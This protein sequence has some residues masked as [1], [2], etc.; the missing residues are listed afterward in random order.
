MGSLVGTYIF[1]SVG[2][3]QNDDRSDLDLLAVVQNGSGKVEESSVLACVPTRFANMKPSISWYGQDRIREMYQNGEL[4]AWH[5]HAE[6][7]PVFELHPFLASLGRPQPYEDSALDVGSFQK[8]LRGIPEQIASN[9]YNVIYE[10]GL[11]YVCV[12]NIAMAASWKLCRR[13]DFSRY[14]P[15]NLGSVGQCPISIEEYEI[16]MACRMASQRGITPPA[17]LK[18]T[19]VMDAYSRLVPWTDEILSALNED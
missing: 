9:Q 5:L 2:R 4:F 7:I 11:I 16:T 10:A 1:G 13:P 17:R 14:S 19:F 18:D 12:R 6:T 15:F 8:V 3:G